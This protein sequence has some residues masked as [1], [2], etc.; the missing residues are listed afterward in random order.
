MLSHAQIQ[1]VQ[2]QN[3][4]PQNVLPGLNVLRWIQFISVMSK[5]QGCQ[6][7]FLF[8]SCWPMH[9]QSGHIWLV[10][11]EHCEFPHLGLK[12]KMSKYWLAG[13][14]FC[15]NTCWRLKFSRTWIRFLVVFFIFCNVK[16]SILGLYLYYV[17][18]DHVC[19]HTQTHFSGSQPLMLRLKPKLLFW[20][21]YFLKNNPW[22]SLVH[23]FVWVS[24][25]YLWNS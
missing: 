4:A 23:N 10:S 20:S 15:S 25:A 17:Y 19:R 22:T 16:K 7:R 5:G 1:F 11:L 13:T 18:T 21:L 12:A 9:P 3:F 8:S 24:H 6:R 14:L 2:N